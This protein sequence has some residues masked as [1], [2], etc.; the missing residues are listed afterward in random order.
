MS[1]EQERVI[2]RLKT[3]QG[4]AGGQA[5][6]KGPGR[7]IRVRQ[8]AALVYTCPISVFPMVTPCVTYPDLASGPFF[9]VKM[10]QDIPFINKNNISPSRDARDKIHFLIGEDELGGAHKLDRL[11][12]KWIQSSNSQS[13][14]GFSDLS[15]DHGSQIFT[16]SSTRALVDLREFGLDG[17]P[18]IFD[19]SGFNWPRGSSFGSALT[20]AHQNDDQNEFDFS[21]FFRSSISVNCIRDNKDGAYAAR[22][23]QSSGLGGPP[24]LQYPYEAVIPTFPKPRNSSEFIVSPLPRATRSTFSHGEDPWQT[25]E[26]EQHEVGGAGCVQGRPW[27]A[28]TNLCACDWVNSPCSAE[29]PELP[30][31]HSTD[32]HRDLVSTRA[33]DVHGDND[34]IIVVTTRAADVHRNLETTRVEWDRNGEGLLRPT[35]GVLRVELSEAALFVRDEKLSSSQSPISGQQALPRPDTQVSNSSQEDGVR[36]LFKGTGNLSFL[37]PMPA[38]RTTRW[39]IRRCLKAFNLSRIRRLSSLKQIRKAVSMDSRNT[40]SGGKIMAGKLVTADQL[41]MLIGSNH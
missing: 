30:A 23:Q 22:L 9:G 10:K 2:A 3:I 24:S 15:L 33:V 12:S 21:S 5:A 40:A 26:D 25:D 28:F 34:N 27:T 18:F 35:E 11:R 38:P 19:F 1:E 7:T 41:K 17:F 37:V 20:P 13:Q 14:I 31:L 6:A 8:E 39:N 36:L 29:F 16:S 32:V 4:R